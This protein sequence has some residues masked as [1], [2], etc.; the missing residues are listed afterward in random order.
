MTKSRNV[1]GLRLGPGHDTGAAI[2][3]EIDGEL[4]CVAIAEERLSREKSSRKFPENS[5]KACL[6]EFGLNPNQLDAIV[7]EKTVWSH[8]AEW[9]EQIPGPE[10]AYFNDPKEHAFFGSV[11]NVPC[12][13][14][15]HHLLHAAMAWH[16]TRW[17]EDGEPGC[18]LVIDGRG[19][20]WKD[21]AGCEGGSLHDFEPVYLNGKERWQLKKVDHSAETQSVFVG[22]GRSIER[23][24]VSLRSGIGFFYAWLTECVLGFDHMHAGKSMGLAAYGDLNRTRFLEFPDEIMSGIDTDLTEFIYQSSNKGLDFLRRLDEDPTDPYFA[25]AAAWGQCM[26]S[27][28]VMHLTRHAI[29]RTGA[30]RLG[31]AGGVALNV[32]ANRQIHDELLGEEL[33]DF[34]VQPAASDA[35]L[36]MGAALLGYYEILGGEAP[37]QTNQVYLGPTVSTDYSTEALI[38][39]GGQVPKNLISDVADLLLDNKIV[40]WFQGRSEH[41]PR[42]LGARSILCWPRAEWMKDHLNATVKHR[43][44]FRPFAPIVQEE[45]ASEIFDADF[46]VPYMLL[47]T[48]V[49]E[50]HRRMIPAVTHAD[51]SGRLQTVARDRTP[52]LYELLGE[53]R[54]R[55]GVGVLLNTS[56]NDN[57][58]PIVETCHDAINCFNST[59]IDALV[60]G[61]ALLC[62][63]PRG[64][65]HP[66]GT[67]GN[68]ACSN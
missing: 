37:F 8:G 62:K 65:T 48:M 6:S 11:G 26:L 27:R 14:A 63:E 45:H 44:A 31:Y 43:E 34:F 3:S 1:L 66:E 36:A 15:N 47:N 50:S 17:P 53:I 57:A 59:N 32:V 7:F 68:M 51:G 4:R 54:A 60:C 20:T 9:Y 52:Q 61:E 46:P 12:Y 33:D 41:G 30:R 67:A 19:S 56:F 58:E 25:D 16:N 22:R 40:G 2:V 10:W 23:V 64:T 5:I 38:A 39:Q 21:G 29:S 55:D 28:A 35:G 13:Y 24:D 49:Q 18:L 42:A